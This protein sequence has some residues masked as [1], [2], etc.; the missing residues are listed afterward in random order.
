MTYTFKLSRR[1]AMSR[2]S[3][4]IALLALAAACSENEP[5]N[6]PTADTYSLNRPLQVEVWPKA[7]TAEVNQ[8]I[9]LAARARL[10][11]G[12][13]VSLA[14]DWTASGGTI[15][16][17]GVFSA[18]TAGTYKLEGKRRGGKRGDTTTV[19]VIDS[20]PNLTAV[21]LSPDTATVEQSQTRQFV[22]Q[23][24]LSDGSTTAV[25]TVWQATGGTIDAGGNYVAGTTSG[26]YHVI[27]KN[28]SGT[29]ADTA[30]VFVPQAA[31]TL[32]ALVLTPASTTL[33]PGSSQQFAVQGRL[34]DGSMTTVT[35][36]YDAA[37]GTITSSGLFTAGS[38][39]G[40][41]RVIATSA[42]GPADTSDVTV[43]PALASTGPVI[44]PG[45]RSGEPGGRCDRV[46]GGLVRGQTESRHWHPDRRSL[47][48]PR[49]PGSR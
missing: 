44:Y 40:T 3:G 23:G 43:T 45:T 33:A 9:Q 18:T 16:A 4:M 48:G 6:A 49:L 34:S 42:T 11:S 17:D 1:L 27:A 47:A 12:D 13:T 38:V 35:A 25:G 19:V 36:Q 8:P 26:H 2:Y 5:L 37:G 29:L 15:S 39:A 14:V 30:A 10:A 46:A 32:S 28:V 7:V 21:I 41:Y 22:A 24:E 31:P 20:V